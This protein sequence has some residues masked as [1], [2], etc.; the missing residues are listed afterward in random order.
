M[1][2]HWSTLQNKRLMI[3]WTTQCLP[4][5]LLLCHTPTLNVEQQSRQKCEK[6]IILRPPQ[7]CG[8]AELLNHTL[9]WQFV[10]ISNDFIVNCDFSED[11]T[12]LK[13]AE[14]LEDGDGKSGLPTL[15]FN[16]VKAVSIHNCIGTVW[17]LS[18]ASGHI[19]CAVCMKTIWI[20]IHIFSLKQK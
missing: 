14:L 2:W 12:S 6:C 5:C 1:I 7:V 19:V 20:A 8:Q 4:S 15:D 16:T 9:T 13:Q 3:C 17:P 18:V 10:F 11:H